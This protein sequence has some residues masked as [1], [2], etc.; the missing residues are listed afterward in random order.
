[1]H[2]D[3]LPFRQGL[4]HFLH[5]LQ[6]DYPFSFGK[7]GNIVL[8]AFYIQNIVKFNLLDLMLGFYKNKVLHRIGRG[9][10]NWGH[11]CL[12]GFYRRCCLCFIVHLFYCLVKTVERNRLQ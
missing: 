10:S 11:K 1:M 4:V 7:N 3:K 2:P 9:C 12:N 8:Q 6:S 5:V